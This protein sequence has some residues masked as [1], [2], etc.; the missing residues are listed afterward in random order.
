LINSKLWL[1][2]PNDPIVESSNNLTFAPYNF[3][4]PHLKQH[5]DK[6]QLIGEFTDDDG[7]IQK[8][9]NKWSQIY[10]FTKKEDETLNYQ[11]LKP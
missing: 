6:A 2:T 3:K 4:Y 1:Y 10:D 11:L 7:V 9:V 8:K 5:V